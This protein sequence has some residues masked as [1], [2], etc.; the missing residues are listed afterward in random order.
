MLEEGIYKCI[1]ESFRP[2]GCFLMLMKGN[3][4]FSGAMVQQDTILQTIS[5]LI[6]SKEDRAL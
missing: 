3:H 6:S 1:M 4:S 5:G 2:Q